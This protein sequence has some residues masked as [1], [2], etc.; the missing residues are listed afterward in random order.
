[1]K[2]ILKNFENYLLSYAHIAEKSLKFYRSDFNHFSAWLILKIKTLGVMAE[3]FTETIPFISKS[4]AKEYTKYLLANNI[5]SKTINRRLST[6]RHLSRFLV[7]SQII[8]TDFMEDQTNITNA[9]SS[10]LDSIG[11]FAQFLEREKVSKNTSRNYLSD[12]RQF[13]VWISSNP[14]VNTK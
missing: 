10:A 11:G 4:L 2:N 9:Q 7:Y 8:D 13:L 6:L 3:D 1:M 14:N 12:I 5:P